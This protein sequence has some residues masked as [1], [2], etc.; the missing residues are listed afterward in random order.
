MSMFP[1]TFTAALFVRDDVTTDSTHVRAWLSVSWMSPPDTACDFASA[2]SVAVAVTTRPVA[3]ALVPSPPRIDP[4]RPAV[5]FEVA[6]VYVLLAPKPAMPPAVPLALARAVL[7]RLLA[8][9]VTT[10]LT[11]TF[12]PPAIVAVTV[13][14]ARVS[15]TPPEMP[16]M[17]PM[18]PRLIVE[19][20]S[21]RPKVALKV[22]LPPLIELLVPAVAAMTP[23]GLPGSP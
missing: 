12:A 16:A 17:R 6:L 15:A 23:T 8:M 10:P 14:V 4:A 13:G 18:L 5:T 22:T 20:E 7:P 9:S 19:R 1:L 11:F 3:P 2:E 21:L